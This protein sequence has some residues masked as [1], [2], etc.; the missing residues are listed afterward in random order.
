[1]PAINPGIQFLKDSN[2]N[3]TGV[4]TPDGQTVKIG[5]A[6][7]STIAQVMSDHKGLPTYD[8]GE[9]FTYKNIPVRKIDNGVSTRYTPGAV[10]INADIP[11]PNLTDPTNFGWQTIGTIT[12][13]GGMLIGRNT[14]TLNFTFNCTTT[15]GGASGGYFFVAIGSEGDGDIGTYWL[16]PSSS[17]TSQSFT[18][19]IV[20]KDSTTISFNSS[21]W[22]VWAGTN[23]KRCNLLKDVTIA[24]KFNAPSGNGRSVSLSDARIDILD[25]TMAPQQGVTYRNPLTQPFKS[26]SFWNTPLGDGATFQ[27]A[28][29]AETACA[30]NPKPGGVNSGAYPWVGGASDGANNFVQLSTS[31]PMTNFS[32]ASRCMYAPW[33]FGTSGLTNASF[34]MHAPASA[35]I[36]SQSTD[37]IITLITPDKRYMIE[38][39]GYSYNTTTNTHQLGYCTVWDLYGIGMS[40]NIDQN[41]NLLSE[42]YR[43]SGH[44]VSGGIIRKAELD[45]LAI[46]HVV[47]MQFSNYQQKCAVFYTVFDLTV[48]G[49]TTIAV[50][51]VDALCVAQ[52]Y[53]ALFKVGGTVV[54]GSTSYTIATAGT[55]D[56]TT[57]YTS[58]TVTTAITGSGTW[59]VLGGTTTQA[60]QLT[61]YVWP[62]TCVD[63]QSTVSGVTNFYRGVVPMGAMFGIPQGVDLTTLGIKSAE[64]MALAKA[65]QQFGGVNNDTTYKTFSI[66]FLEAGATQTQKNNLQSDVTAIR[67]ALRMIT[68]ISAATPGGPGNRVTTRP[69]EL[70][71]LY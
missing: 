10:R 60:Q 15:F 33:P 69:G 48:A 66:C 40:N 58:C 49:G 3:V 42:G 30:I 57:N 12:I 53:S 35:F 45:A 44:P 63:G 70:L 25:S 67:N 31:D 4:L 46:N 6:P 37:R 41:V 34:R 32:F 71:P 43:A 21:G 22:G 56:S 39:G 9:Y 38:S 65:F 17:A 18:A 54:L 51:P 1:M 36:T 27:A 62:A 55:Y 50:K 68:N 28:T 20:T 13:P 52:D 59:C 64:G 8:I 61:Q 47:A 26:S 11:Q 14:A 2:G 19:T 29:D 24:F 16:H 5:G 7:A 23:P